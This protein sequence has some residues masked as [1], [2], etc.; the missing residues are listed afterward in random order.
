MKQETLQLTGGNSKNDRRKLDFY[1][2][3][4]AATIALMKF[5]HANIPMFE[6]PCTIWEPACGDR[7]MSNV[8]ESFGH[9]VVSTDIVTGYDFLSCPLPVRA[10]DA[11]ITNPPFNTSAQFIERALS[12]TSCVA[13]LLGNYI[14]IHPKS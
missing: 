7:A 4:P 10:V 9:N 5:L 6:T 13:M 2:T 14:L 3:P 11:I 1:P 8:I 12:H